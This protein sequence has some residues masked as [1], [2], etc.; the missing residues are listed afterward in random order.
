MEID[1]LLEGI[2]FKSAGC[3]FW[4]RDDNGDVWVLL[5][6]H[7]PGRLFW[8]KV[9]YSIPYNAYGG[10]EESS[11]EAALRIGYEETGIVNS[12][13]RTQLFWGNKAGGI[14]VT[15]FS[16]KL[17]KRMDVKKTN[18]FTSFEWFN[19][20]GG[21]P[22][23]DALSATQLDVFRSFVGKVDEKVS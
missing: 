11:L 12:K 20:N 14:E 10:R 4:T 13:E 21:I 8:D 17:S 6:R 22:D 1:K 7:K 9:S 15:V 19:L 5:G 23:L 16:S 3:L 18:N 2:S